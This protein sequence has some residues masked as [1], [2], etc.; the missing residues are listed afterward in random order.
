MFWKPR[1]FFQIKAAESCS[2]IYDI[3]GEDFW[4]VTPCY[5]TADPEYVSDLASLPL[6]F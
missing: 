4:V 6:I 3:I 1:L 5:S 2:Q